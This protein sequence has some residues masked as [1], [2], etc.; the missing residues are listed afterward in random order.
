[1]TDAE[2]LEIMNCNDPKPDCWCE[3]CRPHSVEMRMIVCP[4][5]GNKRC[6]HAIDHRNVCTGSNAVGQKGSSWKH[7]KTFAETSTAPAS[8]PPARAVTFVVPGQPVA[9][10]RA[11]FAK[12]GN[13]VQTYTPE[14]TANYESLVKLCSGQAMAGHAPFAGPVILHL[15]VVM[16]I[17][18]SWSKKKQAAALA[19][20]IAAT[21]KP[22]ADNV[23]KAIK[24]GMNG[25]V[26]VDDAQAVDIRVIKRYG[27][28][29]SV[30]VNV[31]CVN[32]EAA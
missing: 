5:C 7:L 1:M 3:K 17:P 15:D 11:R 22:D 12:R 29:P 32:K 16:A 28:T 21:K 20:D 14:K 24:D 6:P 31:W 25:I 9:K 18:S 23:L 30:S 26:Y 4:T 10:G 13:F 19:G 27:A 8:R 2:F